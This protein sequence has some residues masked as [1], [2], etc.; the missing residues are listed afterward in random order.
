MLAIFLSEYEKKI[1]YIG[2]H[3]WVSGDFC[4]LDWRESITY[5]LVHQRE[6]RQDLAEVRLLH[7]M[8][9]VSHLRDTVERII[10]LLA[11]CYT[12]Y[13]G[14]TNQ[15][16][17][18]WRRIL[19]LKKRYKISLIPLWNPTFYLRRAVCKVCMKSSTRVISTL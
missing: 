7:P 5:S 12:S 4:D 16:F 10:S 8:Q 14:S 3:Y 13:I 19:T 1:I 18:R 17:I 2:S 9:H 11:S 6:G 15:N